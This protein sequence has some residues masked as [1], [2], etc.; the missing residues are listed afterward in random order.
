MTAP[1]GPPAPRRPDPRDMPRRSELVARPVG[2]DAPVDGGE[3][4]QRDA[5]APDSGQ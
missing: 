1:D 4:A 2:A 5:P 3:D